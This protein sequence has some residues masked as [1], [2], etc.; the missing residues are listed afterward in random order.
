MKRFFLYSIVLIL[1]LSSC[2]RRASI[3]VLNASSYTI[4]ISAQQPSENAILKIARVIK[5]QT[6]QESLIN[7]I[8]KIISYDNYL[9]ILT[10]TPQN[11]VFIF[12]SNGIFQTKIT[13]GRAR[14]ELFYPTDISVDETSRQLCVLDYYRTVK[15][16]SFKGKYLS[17][18]S[19]SNP[20][21]SLESVGDDGF[22]LCYMLNMSSKNQYTGYY[23]KEHLMGVYKCPFVSDKAYLIGGL[24]KIHQDSVL[25]A[26]VFSDTVY[27]FNTQTAHF[28]PYFIFDYHNKSAN[29]IE[30]IRECKDL[31]DYMKPVETKGFYPGPSTVQFIKG[32][33]IFNFLRRKDTFYIFDTRQQSLTVHTKLFEDLPNYYGKIGQSKHHLIYAYDIPLLKKY[34]EKHPP[35]TEQGKQIEAMCV[36]ENDNPIVIFANI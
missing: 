6:I 29:R 23:G 11:S 8:S 24:T 9:F 36:N 25:M 35:V 34:F 10:D 17:Q 15:R 4:D 33:L 31:K 5:L 21:F 16:F 2:E 18:S 28:D 19:L 22:Y 13:K 3:P 20:Q 27:L 7:R 26:P 14:N 12:D 32:R 1:Y 30:L